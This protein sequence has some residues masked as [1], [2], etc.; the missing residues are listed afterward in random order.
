[1]TVFDK[2]GFVAGATDGEHYWEF[3][4]PNKDNKYHFKPSWT[5]RLTREEL[6]EL[7]LTIL[8]EFTRMPLNRDED[9]K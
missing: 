2:I 7:F 4:E 5:V 1:M 9:Q 6:Y 3:E 8:T